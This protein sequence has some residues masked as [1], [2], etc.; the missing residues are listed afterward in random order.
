[1]KSWATKKTISIK[2]WK[3]KIRYNLRMM[4]WRMTQLSS[5]KTAH[6]CLPNLANATGQV[7]VKTITKGNKHIRTTSEKV[8]D[9]KR[10]T[11]IEA[12]KGSVKY[13]RIMSMRLK[14]VIHKTN[15]QTTSK[16]SL[17]AST[18]TF[19]R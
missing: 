13:G 5:M 4:L 18:E 2:Q 16:I 8:T 1:M 17:C 11:L 3:K 9:E 12:P 14:V 6:H 15:K 10:E 7:S 19:P